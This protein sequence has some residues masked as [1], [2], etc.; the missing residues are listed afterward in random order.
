MR[1]CGQLEIVGKITPNVASI[2]KIL[3]QDFL[4]YSSMRALECFIDE[5]I[6]KDS[7]RGKVF[8]I[9]IEGTWKTGK[10]YIASGTY[11]SVDLQ[12]IFKKSKI[13]VKTYID[14]DFDFENA[15]K[16]YLLG[17][18]V[19]NNMRYYC[20]NFCY[21]LGAFSDVSNEGEERPKICYEYSGKSTL[22]NYKYSNPDDIK[23][24]FT[25]LLQVFLA[26]EIAQR[27]Y[28]F[29]HG[30]LSDG[31]V[32]IRD[33][34]ATYSVVLNNSTYTFRDVPCPV[35]I[36]YGF[37][38]ATYNGK[39]ESL[40]DVL[41]FD[42]GEAGKYSFLMQGYDAFFLLSDMLS[43]SVGKMRKFFQKLILEIYGKYPYSLNLKSRH[44]QW[45]KI[46]YSSEAAITP[47][48]IAEKMMKLYPHYCT[49]VEVTTR[50]S[51]EINS[52]NTIISQF[53]DISNANIVRDLRKCFSAIPSYITAV[54]YSA[55]LDVTYPSTD[56]DRELLEKFDAISITNV[57]AETRDILSTPLGKFPKGHF[58]DF[59][60]STNFT[61]DIQVYFAIYYM[62]LEL[63]FSDDLYGAF[64]EKFRNSRA[65]HY[66]TKNLSNILAARSWVN[67]LIE[68]NKIDK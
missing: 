35:I 33:G 36:D 66:C 2:N 27:K 40:I 1:T 26:L 37:S 12:T 3:T 8:P 24:I 19:L 32:M 63:G 55:G 30:D 54:Y 61:N 29:M 46:I 23:G 56:Y 4:S 10:T 11:G 14:H 50:K 44:G 31:N 43:T 17:K 45:E 25:L 59:L 20:P 7:Y 47:G 22:Y 62:I 34:K 57:D 68:Y 51:F 38:S 18:T 6:D 49:H 60:N 9:L 21:T 42:P 13:V 48:M 28:G 65:Y 52:L 16:E 5:N 58:Q 39:R 53:Y 15:K 64:A 41:G 67:T